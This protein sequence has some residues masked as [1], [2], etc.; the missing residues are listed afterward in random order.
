MPLKLYSFMITEDGKMRPVNIKA[1]DMASAQ[2]KVK[3]LH[4]NCKVKFLGEV[5]RSI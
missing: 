2:E 3:T 5:I 4:P 1:S